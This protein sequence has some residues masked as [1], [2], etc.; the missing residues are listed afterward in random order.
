[1]ASSQIELANLPHVNFQISTN[2]TQ[3]MNRMVNTLSYSISILAY[4]RLLRRPNSELAKAPL[5]KEIKSITSPEFHGKEHA[6][7]YEGLRKD[8]YQIPV[9]FKQEFA[10]NLKKE[11]QNTLQPVLRDDIAFAQLETIQNSPI[12][13]YLGKLRE[14]WSD[15]KQGNYDDR[16]HIQR[17]CKSL[18]LFTG[19]LQNT[20]SHIQQNVTTSMSRNGK[21]QAWLLKINDRLEWL[22]DQW[23]QLSQVPCPWISCEYRYEDLD[24]IINFEKDSRA[25]I[26]SLL[27]RRESMFKYLVEFFDDFNTMLRDIQVQIT[28]IE[29]YNNKDDTSDTDRCLIRR[30]LYNE[31]SIL[32]RFL[33]YLEEAF[34]LI[35]QDWDGYSKWFVEREEYCTY[36]RD[37]STFRLYEDCLLG[38]RGEAE[39]G[40]VPV[41][42]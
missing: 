13:I 32:N 9:A 25:V 7:S 42:V 16:E 24:E 10:D 28:A 19:H 17:L 15:I 2:L 33:D 38:P 1:M 35:F 40:L 12:L 8:L 11:L 23:Q 6:I 30:H 20:S 41:G 36:T 14:Q 39:N 29:E 31:V 37:V 4:T 5:M 18:S 22:G 26:E 21:A 34:Q 27:D 3:C